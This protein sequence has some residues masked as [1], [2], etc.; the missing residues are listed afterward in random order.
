MSKTIEESYSDTNVEMLKSGRTVVIRDKINDR[1]YLVS[2]RKIPADITWAS[3]KSHISQTGFIAYITILVVALVFLSCCYIQYHAFAVL[4]IS[5]RN[6]LIWF[7]LY[8]IINVICHECAH[9]TALKCCGS[10]IDK[11]GIKL[12]YYVFP[13]FYVRMNKVYLLPQKDRIVVHSAGLFVNVC[14]GTILLIGNGFFFHNSLL[15]GIVNV[16][17]YGII[18]NAIPILK[19][20]G[21]KVLFTIIGEAQPKHIRDYGTTAKIIHY[22]S[23]GMAIYS[24]AILLTNIWRYFIC[25]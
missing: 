18:W 1:Y 17:T 12:N 19:S 9:I 23:Y 21:Q 14:I 24:T 2:S 3:A 15:F 7:F 20:D 22:L 16:F 4:Q 25:S 11:V 10:D 8:S 5:R 13:A 6:G